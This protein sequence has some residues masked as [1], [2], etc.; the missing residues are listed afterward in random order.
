[1]VLE[2]AKEAGERGTVL[3]MFHENAKGLIVGLKPKGMKGIN[4]RQDLLYDTAANRLP[5]VSA[6][7]ALGV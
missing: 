4:I 6:A 3:Y 5:I 7:Q 2:F 1:M